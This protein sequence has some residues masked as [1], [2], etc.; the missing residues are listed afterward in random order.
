[1]SYNVA[2]SIKYK[3]HPN[4]TGGAWNLDFNQKTGINFGSNDIDQMWIKITDYGLIQNFWWICIN[5][6]STFSFLILIACLLVQYSA[7]DKSFKF[8]QKDIDISCWWT[9]DEYMMVKFSSVIQQNIVAPKTML[10]RLIFNQN[11]TFTGGWVV[12]GGWLY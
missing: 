6:F 1:M 5:K 8:K 12:G 7:S 4:K 3:G 11:Y 10:K 9:Q 2:E